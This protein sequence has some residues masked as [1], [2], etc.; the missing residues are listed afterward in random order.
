M[1]IGSRLTHVIESQQFSR[2]QIF[3]ADL[4][5]VHTR[6][7][8]VLDPLN[9]CRFGTLASRQ[10]QR[11][12]IGDIANSELGNFVQSSRGGI[13]LPQG[14]DAATFPRLPRCRAR[15]AR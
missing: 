13:I 1:A 2:G 15:P 9:Q 10:F 11:L 5:P 14:T 8:R 4:N 3:L 7:G 12:A 6:S